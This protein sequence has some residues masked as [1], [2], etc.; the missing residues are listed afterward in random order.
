MP[1]FSAYKGG[2]SY[3]IPIEYKNLSESELKT[4]A[5]KYFYLAN[6]VDDG[7]VKAETTNALVL[8]SILQHVNP[9]SAEY[10]VR[11]GILYDKIKKDRYAKGCFSSAISV[12]PSKPE[13]YFYF[14]EFYY[15]R[16][17]YR[18]ALRYYTRALENSVTPQY[19]LYYKLGD[20]YEKFGDTKNALKYLK[21]ANEQSP[22]EKLDAK[23]K[24]TESFDS[25]NKMYYR[26]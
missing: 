11:A 10:Y 2:I 5:D 6:Q 21:L 25:I 15:K 8:Y 3:S 12:E 23:I 7:V 20:I 18:Q 4:K 22:N 9:Q 24:R 13:S 16:G 14:G 17:Q 1:V 26:D 19:D